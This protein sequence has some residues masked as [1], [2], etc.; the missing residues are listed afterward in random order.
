MADLTG[1]QINILKVLAEREFVLAD[2][3]HQDLGRL[4]RLGFAVS[5]TAYSASGRLSSSKVWEISVRGSDFL[6]TERAGQ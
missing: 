1:K 3:S 4:E 5:F 2:W 6:A